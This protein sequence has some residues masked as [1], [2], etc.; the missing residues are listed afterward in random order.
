MHNTIRSIA[1]VSW[2]FF[3]DICHGCGARGRESL[4]CQ[5]AYVA[6][7]ITCALASGAEFGIRTQY[8]WH[9]ILILNAMAMVMWW[10]AASD[11]MLCARECGKM[12][13][14]HLHLILLA[15]RIVCLAAVCVRFRTFAANQ[16]QPDAISSHSETVYSCRRRIVLSLAFSHWIRNISFYVSQLSWLAPEM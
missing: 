1:F 16:A 12:I 10:A 11:S 3:V 15:S 2:G 8:N 13:L 6:N 4:P 14:E 9:F 5:R 7:R